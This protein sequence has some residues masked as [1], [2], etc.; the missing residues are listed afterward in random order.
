MDD[1]IPRYRLMVD[2]G[3]PPI[4]LTVGQVSHGL[5]LG[6]NESCAVVLADGRVSGEHARIQRVDGEVYLTD[7][8]STN[9]TYVDNQAL[10]A[11]QPYLLGVRSRFEIRP[12]TLTFEAIG[13][14][15]HV[16]PHQ[17]HLPADPAAGVP[18]ADAH[19]PPEMSAMPQI[20]AQ[21]AHTLMQWHTPGGDQR[22][23]HDEQPARDAHWPISE[24]ET[25]PGRYLYELPALFHTPPARSDGS[26]AER[27]GFL[28]RYVKI[29]EAIWE[30]L[31]QRQDHLALYFDPRTCPDA[32]IPLLA[33]W[34][35]IVFP[36]DTPHERRRQVLAA[37]SGL[38]ELRG[39]RMGV[40]EAIRVYTGLVARITD[41]EH[42]PYVFCIDVIIPA[43]STVRAELIEAVVRIYKPAHAG[44]ILKIA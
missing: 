13:T 3:R 42:A 32:C 36:A 23:Q 9:H 39:T 22:H 12:F 37:A 44:Y 21:S 30:P 25:E 41:V 6:R 1:Q 14:E 8:G 16:H 28:S 4:L 34:L 29:F 15:T 43:D 19:T 10:P 24:E 2:D 18:E 5:T 20:P 38:A 17:S 11:D 27:R 31:E 33:H 7:V 26:H 40:I 35:G